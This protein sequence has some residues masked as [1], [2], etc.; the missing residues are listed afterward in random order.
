MA[1]DTA[2][3]AT[4][5]EAARLS[6]EMHTGSFV[7][8][9]S[10]GTG[11]FDVIGRR[12]YYYVLSG[13]LVVASLLLI[14]IKG[15]H[16]GT[17]FA[18]GS[19]LTFTPT[20]SVSV[21]QVTEVLD[22]TYGNGV[23]EKV[24]T[25]GGKT[26]QATMTS[27]SEPQIA[28]GKSALTKAFNLPASSV[29]GS[30][31]SSTWGSQISDRAIL[32]VVIFFIAVGIFIWV[33]YEKRVAAGALVSVLHDVIVTSGIYSLAGFEVTPATVIGMLTILG[34]SLYDTVVVYDKVQENAKGMT[35]LLRR[36]YPET[37]N[38]A[39]NQTLMRSLNTSLIALLPV[40][41]LL[42][43]GVAVLGGGTLKDLALVLLVGMLV[44]AYSSIFV[45]VPVAVDLKMREITIRNHTARVLAK[46]KQD[47]TIVDAD[48]DPVGVK[49]ADGTVRHVSAPVKV[50]PVTVGMKASAAP[51]PGVKPQ[52]PAR[53][54][55]TKMVNGKPV[56]EK[57]APTTAA[58][59]EP[60]PSSIAELAS[61]AVN[62]P[63][64]TAKPKPGSKAA[65]PTGK[66]G[67]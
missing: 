2:S 32:A 37:A 41:G 52:R 11:A 38:L 44:G 48:G 46:R 29:S 61:Q 31:V 13:F 10:T 54:A 36:T 59:E 14:I 65:R 20:N 67:R 55:S 25:L 53:P 17:D 21:A 24:Q 5:D 42:V 43:A 56:V 23:V 33:R 28:A 6:R 34:F 62:R 47:G 63:Q 30:E 66:R 45:A 16:L 64:P 18:G 57:A 12:R 49:T 1:T 15:F 27:L 51:R 7:S 39:V 8:R 40:V 58:T 35:S 9:L 19:K 60:A 22:K 26:L 4:H 3:V 50:T